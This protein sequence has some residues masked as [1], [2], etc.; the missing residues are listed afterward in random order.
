MAAQR[1]SILVS[2]QPTLGDIDLSGDFTISKDAHAET[3][4]ALQELID[5]QVKEQDVVGSNPI[6]RSRKSYISLNF[7]H[8]SALLFILK[9]ISHTGT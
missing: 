7:S 8:Y 5:Q 6:T 1:S 2:L 9:V 3:R 4:A